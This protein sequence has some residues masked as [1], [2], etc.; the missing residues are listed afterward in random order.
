MLSEML[1]PQVAASCLALC[2]KAGST[3]VEG[4]AAPGEK[5]GIP[6]LSRFQVI[7]SPHQLCRLWTQEPHSLPPLWAMKGQTLS[8]GAWGRWTPVSMV[9]ATPVRTEEESKYQI[10]QETLTSRP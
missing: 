5:R 4:K 2:P 9:L 10:C 1:T 7:P 8:P 3:L 6:S